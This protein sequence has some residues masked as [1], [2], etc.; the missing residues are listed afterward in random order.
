LKIHKYMAIALVLIAIAALSIYFY[1]D[2]IARNVANSV[3]KDS[4]LVVT[5][6][7]INSIGAD[8]VNF[9]ELVL[10]WSSGTQIRITGIVLPTKVRN[11]Q[12]SLL[13]IDELELIPA[14]N[15]DQPVPIAA[16][17]A[18]IFELP[19]NVPYSAVQISRVITDDLPPLT[20]V[21]WESTD[22]G[23]L[24]RLNIGSFAVAVGI[25]PVDINEHRVSITATTSDDVVAL[26][27]ALAVEREGSRFIVSGQSTTRVAPLLP[28]LHAVGMV[29]ARIASL[30]T[31]LWGA[32]NTSIADQVRDPIRVEATLQSD[33]ELSLEYQVDDQSLMH[34][35]VLTH[36]PTVTMVEYPSLNWH[37]Q[38]ESGDMRISMATI[39]DFPVSVTAL[40]CQAGITCTL[41]AKIAAS[42]ISLGG[43]AIASANV[44]APITVT[45]NEQTRVDIAASSTAIFG[46]VSN[47]A[48]TVESIDLTRFAGATIQVDDNGW[49]GR[50]DEAH[51]QIDGIAAPPG[52]SGSLAT[53][54]S[55]LT[56]SE[57]GDVITSAYHI[58][59]ESAQLTLGELMWSVP[60]F[61]G[62]WEISGDSFSAAGTVPSP[63]DAIQAK[64]KLV[65]DLNT[66][67]GGMQLQDASIDFAARNLSDFLSPAP[68]N[69]DVS[70]GRL[71][72]ESDLNWSAADDYNVSGTMQL[73]VDGVAAFR[74]DI[75]LTGLSTALRA[76]I[77]TQ[78]GHEFEPATVSLDVLDVGLPINQIMADFQIG[79]D[80]SSVQVDALSMGVLGGTMRADPFNYSLEAEANA[81]MLRIDSVQLSLMKALAEFD[82]IDIE[83]SVSGILPVAIMGDQLTI[84]QGQLESDEPGGSI[85]YRAGDAGTDD[86]QLG[87]ATRALSDFEFD[88]LTSQV[89]Y[90]ADGDLILAMKLEGVNPKMDPSQPVVLN[91]NLENNVPQMLR[92]L[93]AT[94]GIQEI[95]ER[96]LNEE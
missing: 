85:R 41:Q 57:S 75:A 40:T 77:N 74:N 90:T 1:R 52:L 82:S 9:D 67:Q 22:A 50:S 48:M 20:D 61:A 54:L 12:S 64:L 95:F 69:W 81:I 27:L 83:G 47:Q 70:A 30:D 43:L 96:R 42:D 86:S 76:S 45:V 62:T 11:I 38:I 5:G 56:I 13:K 93:Q 55:N 33:G 14:G 78:A 21:S 29:P 26:A 25:E 68:K 3:L 80:L 7:S 89:T 72:M 88:S 17:L 49:S 59:A 65:H 6:L 84:T 18:S 8:I 60:N 58:G 4:D 46:G 10:E 71:F 63:D 35:Q 23:Q 15:S 79:A 94:R 36:A 16:T 28:V 51:F 32:V 2:S 92:S 34:I 53:T 31:L 66:G 37:A 91:L 19:Q 87:L 73:G 24:V 44:S 39:Q